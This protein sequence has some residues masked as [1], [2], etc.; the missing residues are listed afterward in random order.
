MRDVRATIEIQAVS[1][2]SPSF[3]IQERIL[4]LLRKNYNFAARGT[5]T[6][7]GEQEFV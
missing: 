7:D 1:R 5:T 2:H 6:G 3:S 4:S